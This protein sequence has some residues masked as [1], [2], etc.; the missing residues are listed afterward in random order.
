M[1]KET[2]A[3]LD[4]FNTWAEGAYEV[5]VAGS[6]LT[7]ALRKLMNVNGMTNTGR[8]HGVFIKVVPNYRTVIKEKS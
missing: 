8:Y 6:S 7:P 3:F 5:E 1:D 2:F 4:W